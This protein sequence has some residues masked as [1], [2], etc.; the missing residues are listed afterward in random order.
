MGERTL[1]VMD[2][3]L[4]QMTLAGWVHEFGHTSAGVGIRWTDKGHAAAKQFRELFDALGRQMSS[5]E[6]V[7][8]NIIIDTMSRYPREDDLQ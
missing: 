8:L 2:H 3:V 1:R 4:E 7:A 5:E 6:L